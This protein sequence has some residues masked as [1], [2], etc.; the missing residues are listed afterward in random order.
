MFARQAWKSDEVWLLDT[1]EELGLQ[2]DRFRSR[3]FAIAVNEST[4]KRIG[5]GRLWEHDGKTAEIV[6][7]AATER[8]A[9]ASRHIVKHLLEQAGGEYN[10]VYFVPQNSAQKAV[11]TTLRFK[12]DSQPAG[13]ELLNEGEELFVYEV[14]EEVEFDE[15]S[16]QVDAEEVEKLSEEFGMEDAN[17]KY[18]V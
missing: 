6:S 1:I 10:R 9:E 12:R 3:E 11:A 15:E 14:E 5:I 4:E 8:E 7:L 17:T 13:I 16:E 18:S 2:D